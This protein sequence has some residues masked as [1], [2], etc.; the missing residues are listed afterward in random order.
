M[1]SPIRT[2]NSSVL[3]WVRNPPLAVAK[4]LSAGEEIQYNIKEKNIVRGYA[5]D[6]LGFR[7]REIDK[8]HRVCLR[9]P[10]S[11]AQDSIVSRPDPALSLSLIAV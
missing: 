9:G 8:K 10:Q 6:V 4:W 11:L 1:A 5:G 7:E 2:Q 3:T